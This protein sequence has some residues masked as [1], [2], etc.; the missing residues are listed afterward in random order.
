MVRHREYQVISMKSLGLQQASSKGGF[1]PIP[2]MI[3]ELFASDGERGN[4]VNVKAPI[5]SRRP[6]NTF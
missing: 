1:V 2:M 4:V 3:F 6:L 5:R